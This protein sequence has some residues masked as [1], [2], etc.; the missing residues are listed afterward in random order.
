MYR[1]ILH[2]DMNSFFASVELLSFPELRGKPVAVSGDPSSRH[3]IILAKNEHAKK[4]GIKTAETIWQAKRKCPDLVLLPPHHEKYSEYSRGINRIYERYTDLVE[5]FSIDESWLDVTGTMHLFGDGRTIADDIRRAIR[6]ELGLTASVGVSFNKIF[7]KLGSDYKKPDATTV[8]SPENWKDIVFPLPVS[9]LLFVGRNSSEALRR[10]GIDTIGQ[11]AACSPEQLTGMFGKLGL[12]LYQYANGLDD[13]PVRRGGYGEGVKS[14]GNGTTFSRDLC[15]RDDIKTGIAM[16]SDM[17]A[18]RLRRH[19]LY[20]TG[21]Q[22]TIRDP[23]FKTI[24]RQMQLTR[25]TH[26]SQEIMNASMEIIDRCWKIPAPIRMLTVTALRPV[27][28]DELAVQLDLLSPSDDR[29]REKAESIEKAMDGIRGKYGSG[30]IGYGAAVKKRLTP[31]D[32]DK[33]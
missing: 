9:S 18:M 26:L 6:E 12:Q 10:C 1:T 2:C 33:L 8:I 30:A 13:S 5:P 21:I 20:A 27:P 25:G 16:L 15:T 23:S 32:P 14:V 29:S 19:G 24:T 3:G 31:T 28:A 22:V 17:V 11:L 4:Y 7:A